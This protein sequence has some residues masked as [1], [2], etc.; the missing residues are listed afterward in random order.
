MPCRTSSCSSPNNAGCLS[1][2]SGAS[3]PIRDQI[4]SKAPLFR[5]VFFAVNPS[6][7]R[8]QPARNLYVT[9][10]QSKKSANFVRH[11]QTPVR[12]VCHARFVTATIRHRAG[13]GDAAGRIA[14]CLRP[15]KAAPP[16]RRLPLHPP[17]ISTKRTHF[18]SFGYALFTMLYTYFSPLLTQK[19]THF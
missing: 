3:F 17:A 8:P 11:I 15:R 18:N 6:H 16:A 1:L 14:E 19:R 12:E 9:Y 7:P 5:P 4:K 13:E 2:C 10:K